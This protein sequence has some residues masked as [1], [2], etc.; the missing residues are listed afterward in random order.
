[1]S[2]ASPFEVRGVI[3]G[4]YGNP[5]THAQR[6]AMVDWL[7]DHGLNTFVYG[8]K[9]DPSLRRRW[10]RP[11]D[12]LALER[13]RE[14]A[15]RC[16]DRGITLVVAISPGLTIRYSDA[17]DIAA[18]TA[19]VDQVRAAGAGGIAVLLDDI[20]GELQHAA[21]LET[22]ASLADAHAA[23]LRSV[24]AH[25][26]DGTWLIACPWAYCGDP[27]TSEYLVA[28]AAGTDPALD[29]FW[30][31]PRIC[32]HAIPLA[33]A[34]AFAAVTGR[35]P[36]YWDNY[37]VN[38]VAM[39][40]ELHVG[41]YL[42]RDPRLAEA[43]R[44]VIANPMELF[45]ASRVPLGTIAEYL[46]DPAGYEPE[47]AWR[48]AIAETAGAVDDA[49]AFALVT[50]NTRS[51]CLDDTD[52]P[53][54][55]DALAALVFAYES[56]RD[57]AADDAA[58]AGSPGH[59]EAAAEAEAALA[60]AA[61]ELDAVATVLAAATH[62]LLN[63]AVANAQLVSECRPWIEA[64]AIG[65]TAMADLATLA[66]AGHARLEED[67]RAVLLPH[68]AELRRRRVRVFGDALDMTLAD[69]METHV[70]PGEL[71]LAGPG[72]GDRT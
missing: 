65:A 60:A 55:T 6:L 38:D 49:E 56:A 67:A 42:G 16:A 43:A 21:D 24:R 71:T 72:G 3:E 59:A 63:G 15:A 1:M 62:H 7:A 41:P 33:D 70:K 47:A 44:G 23:L 27:A 25:V 37:P 40:F 53:T 10:R 66:S 12:T 4:F 19:K 2:G 26:G 8:P 64:I 30:T 9:D 22:F 45:E 46:A 50:E 39:G 57:A 54:V 51:S 32:S 36:L 29:L 34:E 14:L 17:S 18:L 28:L 11:Y 69:L 58:R 68:L 48:R 5:W 35:R 52:A 61:R 20:P 31:G 13:L